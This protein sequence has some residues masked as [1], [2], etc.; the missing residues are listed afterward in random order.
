MSSETES[1]PSLEL[2]SFDA[3]AE[4][5]H[6]LN[7]YDV[8]NGQVRPIIIRAILAKERELAKENKSSP[9][10]QST[11]ESYSKHRS[12]SASHSNSSQSRDEE[13]LRSE[14]CEDESYEPRS[15][16]GS[17]SEPCEDE[18]YSR[19]ESCEPRKLDSSQESSDEVSYGRSRRAA[20]PIGR[21]PI[22]SESEEGLERKPSPIRMPLNE[23]EVIQ[24]LQGSNNEIEKKVN[25][26]RMKLLAK[27][28]YINELYN[29]LLKQLASIKYGDARIELIYEEE[30]KKGFI[31]V[32]EAFDRLKWFLREQG[33]KYVCKQELVETCTCE[34]A[35][36]Y[37]GHRGVYHTVR[38]K[39]IME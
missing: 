8:V 26:Y 3:L 31:A 1:S 11:T 19:S 35:G 38:I 15:N 7:I 28:H 24:K 2:A 37:Y 9:D 21:R 16:E 12:E 36:K 32:M 29:D 5:C 25:D 23:E 18:S 33:L 34:S 39:V 13:E 4:A 10:H 17:R 14:P 6:S 20:T 27:Q 22:R 30:D